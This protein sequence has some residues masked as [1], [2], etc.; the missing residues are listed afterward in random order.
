EEVVPPGAEPLLHGCRDGSLVWIAGPSGIL[1]L[2]LRS[3][4]RVVAA[5]WPEGAAPSAPAAGVGD[6]PSPRVAAAL[7]RVLYRPG[8]ALVWQSSS[9]RRL[10]QPVGLARDG[11]LVVPSDP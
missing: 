4:E 10:V 11:A 1:A 2:S 5:P 7:Q 9:S 8:G 3:L 6:V